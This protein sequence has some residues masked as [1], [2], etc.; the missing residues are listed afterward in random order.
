MKTRF[1]WSHDLISFFS[2]LIYRKSLKVILGYMATSKIMNRTSHCNTWFTVN[3]GKPINQKTRPNLFRFIQN[4]FLQ[5]SQPVASFQV[6]LSLISNRNQ[7]NDFRQVCLAKILSILLLYFY[8]HAHFCWWNFK[9]IHNRYWR[10]WFSSE[11]SF[12]KESYTLSVSSTN[13]IFFYFCK[14][15]NSEN[16]CR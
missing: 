10:N 4:G 5:H 13:A 9:I 14:F 15:E 1:A 2:K 12:S 11:S 3:S 16:K 8:F 6:L 7:D